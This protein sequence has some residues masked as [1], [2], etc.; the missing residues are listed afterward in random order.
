MR[1]GRRALA[2]GRRIRGLVD[3]GGEDGKPHGHKALVVR[4]TSVDFCP[5]VIKET[6]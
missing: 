2:N 5:T 3:K 1:S 4:K 6:V